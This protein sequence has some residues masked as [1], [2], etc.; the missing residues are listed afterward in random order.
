[1]Q[2]NHTRISG[3]LLNFSVFLPQN[4]SEAVSLK[5]FV[6]QMRYTYAPHKD[7]VKD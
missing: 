1:M 4:V 5:S 6:P 3:Q 7:H 2:E